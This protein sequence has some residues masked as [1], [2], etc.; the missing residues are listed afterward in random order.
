[1]VIRKARE[2]AKTA[3]GSAQLCASLKA[4]IEGAVHAVRRRRQER[5]EARWETDAAAP[6]TG[7]EEGGKAV[8]P[9]MPG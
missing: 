5:A 8:D 3:C 2:Q 9:D 1:M 4:G 7:A 6:P